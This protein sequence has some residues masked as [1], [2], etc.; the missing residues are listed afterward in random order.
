MPRSPM[1]FLTLMEI[2]VKLVKNGV[3]DRVLRPRCY[4]T[5]RL[6][7]TFLSSVFGTDWV[8]GKSEWSLR[9]EASPASPLVVNHHTPVTALNLNPIFHHHPYSLLVHTTLTLKLWLNASLY[10]CQYILNNKNTTISRTSG[11]C[12]RPLCI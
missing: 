3:P 9:P 11:S 6:R 5:R 12:T 2:V 10:G 4:Q 1:F 8:V 7:N